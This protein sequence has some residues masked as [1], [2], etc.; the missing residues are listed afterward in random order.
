LSSRKTFF[1]KNLKIGI[2]SF[3]GNCNVEAVSPQG[4]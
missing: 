2:M 4:I 3:L 1:C